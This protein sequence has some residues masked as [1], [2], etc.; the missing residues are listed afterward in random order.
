MANTYKNIVITPSRSSNSDDPKIVFSGANTTTNTDITLR[1]YPTSNG[2][3]SLEGSAGQ[4]FSVTN[5]LTGTIYSVNDVSGIPSIEVLSSGLVKIA[6][7]SGPVV[8]GSNTSTI[9]NYGNVVVGSTTVI[10][11]TGYWVGPSPTTITGPMTITGNGSYVGD[12]GY[13][14]LILQDSGGYPGLNY[15][16]GSYNWLMRMDNSGSYSMNYSTNA[17]TGSGSYVNYFTFGT[18]GTGT[19]TSDWRAPIFYDTNNTAYYVDPNSFSQFSSLSCNYDFRA[20]FISSSGGSTFSANH[21]SMGKDIANGSWTSPHYSDLIIGYHT[22]VRIGG[23]YS[24]VRFYANSPTTD[25]NNDGNGDGGEA[26]LMTVG[27]YVGTA[28]STDV[29]VNNNLFAGS[30]MRAPIFYD[31][32]DTGYYVD[33]NSTSSLTSVLF[34][35]GPTLAKSGTTGSRNLQLQGASG[36]DIG[37]VGLNSSGSFC[38]QLYAATTDYGF[39]SSAWGGWDL[40][41]A[42]GG[43]LYLNNQ[44]TYYYNTDTTY[45]YRVYGTGDIRSPLFYDNDDTGYYLNAN[46]T[47]SL[48]RIA[49]VRSGNNVYTDADYGYGLVGAYSSTR[50]QGVYAMGD[51]Y[52]LPA[53]GTTTGSLYGMAWSHPNAGGAAGNLNSHGLLLLQNGSFMAALSTNGTFAADVRGTIFYD[54]SNTGYYVDPNAGTSINVA[55]AILAGGNI[56]AY[57]SDE[58]LKTKLGPIEN[59]IDKVKTLDGFYY[60]ANEV[61]Q[62]LG[63]KVKRELGLSAQQVQAI[64]PEIVAP[65]PI[66]NRYL[67]IH[68]ERVVPLLVEAIKELNHKHET[69]IAELKQALAALLNKQ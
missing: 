50:Y 29:Y 63:Y 43:A 28:N 69:E 11:S 36:S 67:T 4:L 33:P 3:L 21:Y 45:M 5:D 44:S 25:A 55:G 23:S 14:T 65:A 16:S 38:F 1:M 6:Q 39:L 17:Y 58:R 59:A 48:N 42:N 22:G 56:T 35:G 46:G 20:S 37:L 13:S 68:Y 2:T 41:K 52:K 40:R 66:D 51:S 47:S 57:Y 10:N 15:R 19:A 54:Y 18:G 49:V 7:Y 9:T 30:S 53:D 64:L 8:F 12:K 34:G 26:L 31:T 24:G 27:G 60:Q 62:K 32:N 61:A